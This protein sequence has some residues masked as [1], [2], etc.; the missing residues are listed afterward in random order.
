MTMTRT[1]LDRRKFLRDAEKGREVV[2]CAP[3]LVQ[4]RNRSRYQFARHRH[5]NWHRVNEGSCKLVSRIFSS[6]NQMVAWLRRVDS[7]R[8]AA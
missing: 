6:W 2:I 1:L 3:S 8:R 4:K 5:Q 7:V